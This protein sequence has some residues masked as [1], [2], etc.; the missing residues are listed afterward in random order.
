[1]SIIKELDAFERGQIEHKDLSQSAQSM[2]ILYV[3][4]EACKV[5]D[6]RDLKLQRAQIDALRD[7]GRE[8]VRAECR[9]LFD[10]RQGCNESA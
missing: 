4:K 5:L 1:M 6:I 8:L 7:N 9:R 10:K 3:H 2:V